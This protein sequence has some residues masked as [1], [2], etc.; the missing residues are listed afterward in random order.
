MSIILD[1]TTGITT[2]DLID[3]SLTSGRVVY[4]GAS[5]NLTGSSALTFDGTTATTPRLAFGGTTLPSAGTATIFGRSSDNRLYL[6]SGTGN[7]INFLDGSQNTMLILAPTNLVFQI[8]NAEI[9][10]FTSAGLGIGTSSPAYKLDVVVASNKN[11][12]AF[13]PAS[14]SGISDFSSGGVG[15]NF[16]RP[17][18]GA[19]RNSIYSYNTAANALNNFVI[20]ARSDLVFT[21]GG[22]FSNAVERMRINSSGNVGIGTSSPAQTLH[23]KTSTSA[24]PI[25]LGVLSNATGLPALSFNG[26]YA[27]TTMAG[28]YGNGATS[29]GLYYMV[30]SGNTHVWGIADVT[31]MYLDSI[32]NLGVGTNLPTAKVHAY[33]SSDTPLIA[34]STGGTSYLI[35]KNSSGT[36][37][38]GIATNLNNLVFFTSSDGTERMRLTSAG[39]L[40]I[41]TTAPNNE[42]EVVTSSNPSIS[43]KSTSAVLYSYY[44]GIAGTVESYL[45]TFGQ[46]YSAVYPAGCTALANNSY[47]IILNAN[48]ATGILRFQTADTERARFTS[49]GNFLVGGTTIDTGFAVVKGVTYSESYIRMNHPLNTPSGYGYADFTY[50]TG[51]IGNISQ[52]GTTAVSYNTTSDYRL[53]NTIAPMTGALA[54]VALLKPCTYKWN[55]DG[56]NGEGFIAHEL[57][58]VCPSAVT[59]EKDA[60]DENGKPKYQGVDTS[61]LVATLTA[62]IQEQQAIIESLKARLDAA[63]L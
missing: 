53:K 33:T 5:G 14:S 52:N 54:K 62:A 20:Q 12:V 25:T 26:A 29:S 32:G 8:S 21:T 2:P 60:V 1:G 59:G 27:S 24:V 37:G 16:S 49:G 58:E 4:A 46:S 36:G 39:K 10:R 22:D 45:Y 15:W 7:D 56:S 35:V 40:G 44:A 28:I 43:V 63:N 23:V 57:A 18:D 34:E 42:L 9:G 41:G 19:L 47:G 48:N 38:G 6:Q 30:P 51:M 55:A 11:V 31:K 3:S 17:D 50:H 13:T 61:F